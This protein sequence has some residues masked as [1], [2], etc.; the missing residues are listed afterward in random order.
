MK[1][2]LCN[3]PNSYELIGNDPVII[4]EQQGVSPPLG[5]LYIAAYLKSTGRYEISVIDA[6]AEDLTHQQVGERVHQLNPDVVGITAMT[7]TL[8]DVKMVMEEI[9]KRVPNIPIVVG[10]PHV[11]I[12]P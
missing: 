5:I 4:K 6:Q 1:V 11:V 9:R 8:I 2:V 10:G 3:P 12:Y 7:F